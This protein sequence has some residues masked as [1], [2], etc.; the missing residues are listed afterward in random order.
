MSDPPDAAPSRNGKDPDV[1]GEHILRSNQFSKSL[2]KGLAVLA[3]FSPERPTLSVSDISDALGMTRSTAHRYASTLVAL[4]YLQQDEQRRYE[5]AAR[6]S[7]LG[8]SALSAT[9]LRVQAR[10]E[11]EQLRSDTGCTV[12]LAVL[13][14]MAILYVDRLPSHHTALCDVEL[15][16]GAGS[17]LPAYCTAFGKVLLANLPE[18]ERREAIEQVEFSRR[19]P[20]AITAKKALCAEVEQVRAAEVA[21][22]DEELAAGLRSIAAPVYDDGVVVAAV[23][24]TAPSATHTHARLASEVCPVLLD[25]AARISSDLSD[26]TQADA[27]AEAVAS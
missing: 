24:I 13:D 1:G 4:R 17:R 2:A 25:C 3:C 6:V 16:I 26:P 8:R 5:L 7:D 12:G 11:L 18:A 23:G 21:F 10:L 27:D 22:E 20:N 15:P 19:G 9:P 14:G